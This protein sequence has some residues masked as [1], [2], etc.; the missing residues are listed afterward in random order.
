LAER[1]SLGAP[2]ARIVFMASFAI[3]L[4]P[5]WVPETRSRSLE[6]IERELVV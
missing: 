6:E 5:V 3:G 2:A 4:G 1:G